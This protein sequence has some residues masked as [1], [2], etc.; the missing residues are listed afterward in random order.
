MEE[1]IRALSLIRDHNND[2]MNLLKINYNKRQELLDEIKSVIKEKLSHHM[3]SYFHNKE[4]IFQLTELDFCWLGKNGNI[5]LRGCP[6]YIFENKIY[7]LSSYPVGFNYICIDDLTIKNEE[8]FINGLIDESQI[9]N[10]DFGYEL[11]QNN[12]L[13]LSDLL[14]K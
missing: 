13:N 10:D 1:Y 4:L 11:I 8:F 3:N 12:S 9:D 7:K 2:L 5:I 6:Y 14:K